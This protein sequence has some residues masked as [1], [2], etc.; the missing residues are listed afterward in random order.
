MII[1]Y[2]L[3]EDTHPVT[4]AIGVLHT[5][6]KG[7]FRWNL[8][9]HSW[10]ECIFV[11]ITY[12]NIL[13]YTTI[14]AVSGYPDIKA[15]KTHATIQVYPL[16]F[17]RFSSIFLELQTSPKKGFGENVTATAGVYFNFYNMIPDELSMPWPRHTT[18]RI[19]QNKKNGSDDVW[20]RSRVI[21]TLFQ[22]RSD[23]SIVARVPREGH[24]RV[25]S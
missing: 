20:V 8:R 7:E 10:M 11:F 5:G 9:P 6:C 2:I 1:C 23:T 14:Y 25:P 4:H 19:V 16:F 21:H 12:Y 22:T 18:T 15:T 3:D 13:Q 24:W 17:P